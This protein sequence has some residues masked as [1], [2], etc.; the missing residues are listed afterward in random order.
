MRR[1]IRLRE[2]MAWLIV[3]MPAIAAGANS[4]DPKSAAVLDFEL[5]NEIRDYETEASQAA[6]QRR[7]ILISDTLRS[8]LAQRGLYRTVDNNIAANLIAE[9]KSLQDLRSCNGCELD[10]GRALG[11]EVVVSW[12]QKVSNLIL[13]INIEVKDVA[14]GTTLY[15]KS[16]D[17]RGNTDKSWL[18]GINYMVDSIEEKEQHLRCVLRNTEKH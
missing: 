2:F 15:T 6:Q 9:Q 11:A 18:R 3:G 13:N 16:V 17:L 8:E 5:I 1:R 7:L 10:I 4:P 14:S 12:V